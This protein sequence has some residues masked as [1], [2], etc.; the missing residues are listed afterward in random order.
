M[1]RSFSFPFCSFFEQLPLTFAVLIMAYLLSGLGSTLSEY[2]LYGL[3]YLG[4]GMS[5]AMHR[6]LWYS[7]R[8]NGL[9]YGG[10]GSRREHCLCSCVLCECV[11]A[12]STSHPLGGPRSKRGS[13]SVSGG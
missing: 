7:G 6:Y 11:V 5:V 1:P 8:V 2:F 3:S 13:R 10:G 9:R 12:G 4:I